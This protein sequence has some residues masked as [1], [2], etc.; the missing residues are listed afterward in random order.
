MIV[1]RT[2]AEDSEV[3]GKEFAPT[4]NEFDLVNI[5]RYNAYVRLM[6]QGTASK[7]FNMATMAPQKG[8]SEQLAESI[9]QLSR[10]K[11]GRVRADVESEI[12]EA[13]QVADMMSAGQP[14]V[15]RGL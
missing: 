12:L 1:F 3:L 6:V 11:F 4:F 13:S 5:E 8:G 14:A 15:E 10:L 9:R 7:P 2:G